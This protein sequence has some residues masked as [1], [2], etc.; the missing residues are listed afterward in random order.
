MVWKT[1]D[2]TA[3]DEK[4]KW[5]TQEEL[6]PVFNRVAKACHDAMEDYEAYQSC[7]SVVDTW[8]R[9]MKDVHTTYHDGYVQNA[10]WNS[11][12]TNLRSVPRVYLHNTLLQAGILKVQVNVRVN[13]K[14]ERYLGSMFPHLFR[15]FACTNTM[16]NARRKHI[17]DYVCKLLPDIE[18]L[19]QTIDVDTLCESVVSMNETILNGWQVKGCRVGTRRIPGEY[20]R[21]L[22]DD[23]HS[24]R[25]ESEGDGDTT[26]GQKAIAL[27][28]QPE[29][30]LLVHHQVYDG[31]TR[32]QCNYQIDLPVVLFL[33]KG[34]Q[35]RAVTFQY[36]V[37]DFT[38]SLRE[39]GDALYAN[40]VV[41]YR[42]PGKVTV[43]SLSALG[44]CCKKAA[45]G[46]P[47]S[48]SYYV[49][50]R[51]IT[52]A[53]ENTLHALDR[54]AHALD[55]SAPS[56]FP[57]ELAFLTPAV[58]ALGDVPTQTKMATKTLPRSEAFVYDF[59]RVFRVATDSAIASHAIGLY[60]TIDHIDRLQ[61]E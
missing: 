4:L 1:V 31:N 5:F 20:A 25:V 55:R 58:T 26:A 33:H 15:C 51:M 12:N 27:V 44:W 6:K 49:F 3:H 29:G 61:L 35:R 50:H 32:N 2:V 47:I 39:P 11:M 22:E 41:T 21:L 42:L 18:A 14:E 13:N 38:V 57:P 59:A 34:K 17:F 9:G 56:S 54:L 40:K 7:L 37:L 16:T 52:D 45:L 28:S 48:A 19:I 46:D 60:P 10:I 36:S 23:K 30:S 24:F 53:S 43:Q 8:L